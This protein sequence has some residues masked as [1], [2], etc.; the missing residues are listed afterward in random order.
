MLAK[1]A[2]YAKKPM[3]F[4]LLLNIGLWIPR[5]LNRYDWTDPRFWIT[6]VI[7]TSLTMPITYAAYFVIGKAIDFAESLLKQITRK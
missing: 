2:Q 3:I 6:A 4:L 1:I 5:L 7:G